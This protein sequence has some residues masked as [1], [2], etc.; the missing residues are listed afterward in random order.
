MIDR[1]A[2]QGF[3]SLE[4]IPDPHAGAADRDRE[5]RRVR[6]HAPRHRHRTQHEDARIA[7]SRVSPEEPFR[8][9]FFEGALTLLG[10]RAA[11]ERGES[12]YVDAEGELRFRNRDHGLAYFKERGLEFH[13]RCVT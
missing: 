8:T 1:L 13:R 11:I 7:D 5:C 2:A 9:V 6:T 3:H 10:H 4:D 12:G